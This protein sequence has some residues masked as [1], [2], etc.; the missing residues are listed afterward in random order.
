MS[1]DSVIRSSLPMS[2]ILV[3]YNSVET[4]SVYPTV[5]Q[6]LNTSE[7]I[8]APHPNTEKFL[9]ENTSKLRKEKANNSTFLKLNI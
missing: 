7:H 8:R 3:D 1:T 2:L 9:T 5:V 6:S 4:F